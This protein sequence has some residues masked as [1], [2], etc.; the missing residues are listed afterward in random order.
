MLDKNQDRRSGQAESGEKILPWSSLLNQRY[1]LLM[2]SG[3]FS[4]YYRDF[5]VIIFNS[6]LLFV[7][8]NLLASW[9]LKKDNSS[10]KHD[11]KGIP[12]SFFTAPADYIGQLQDST[13]LLYRVYEGYTEDELRNLLTK[14]LG[15][16]DHPTLG[17]MVRP[18]EHGDF[19]VGAEGVRF[20]PIVRPDNVDSLLRS[21]SAIWCLG[22]S[23]TYGHK[24]R[25]AET[26]PYQLSVADSLNTYLNLGAPSYHQNTEINKLILLLKKGY[27]PKKVLFLDGNNDL[28][29]LAR[30]N[31]HP[32]EIPGRANRAYPQATNFNN[33]S[34]ARNNMHWDRL[35]IIVLLQR[36]SDKKQVARQH[37]P[38]LPYEN[39]SDPDA[40]YFHSSMEHYKAVRAIPCDTLFQYFP[41]RILEYYQT[42]QQFVDKLAQAYGFEYEF[43][44]QPLG[45]LHQHNPFIKDFEALRKEWAC[46]DV[47]QNTQQ[48]IRDNIESGALVNFRDLS[49]TGLD[50]KNCFI[51]IVHYNG[52]FNRELAHKILA[53]QQAE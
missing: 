32:A 11:T 13:N 23:T 7:V 2:P 44:F 52:A 42:N 31:F 33:L 4:R 8:I 36:L 40:L 30:M 12:K 5:T 48:V 29:S 51:D 26:I 17:I 35:P 22:G 49:Y 6:L 19:H 10:V 1:S 16:I 28:L 14:G 20:D 41:D 25:A 34:K 21:G 3:K 45:F 39:L 27:L 50:C 46:F 15:M 38:G 18:G 53:P 43:L 24:I 47:M 9:W 37:P